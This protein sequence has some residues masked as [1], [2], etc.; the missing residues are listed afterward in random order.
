M[1]LIIHFKI[2]DLP[3]LLYLCFIFAMPS[4]ILVFSLSSYKAPFFVPKRACKSILSLPKCITFYILWLCSIYVLYKYILLFII[5]ELLQSTYY[6]AYHIPVTMLDICY[7]AAVN[8]CIIYTV[9][10]CMES[11]LTLWSQGNSS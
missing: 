5:T 6:E 9:Q 10:D 4:L 1:S 3:I 2:S 11:I 7:K 8:V